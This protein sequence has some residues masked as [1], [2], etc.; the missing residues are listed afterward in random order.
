MDARCIKNYRPV[1]IKLAFFFTIGTVVKAP[2]TRVGGLATSLEA[3]R[4]GVSA[5]TTAYYLQV[6]VGR[7]HLMDLSDRPL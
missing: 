3:L 1:K 7:Y 5:K 4:F 2:S 6:P